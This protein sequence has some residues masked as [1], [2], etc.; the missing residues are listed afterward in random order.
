MKKEDKFIGIDGTIRDWKTLENDYL[1]NITRTRRSNYKGPIVRLTEL[2]STFTNPKEQIIIR[3]IRRY[4]H[5]II[6]LN[7]NQQLQII[8]DFDNRGYNVLLYDS[9][10]KEQTSFGKQITWAFRYKEFR[11]SEL[12]ELAE[13]LNI[14]ACLYC[15]SQY[16]L[17][18]EQGKSKIAKLQF[19]HF[20]PKSLYPYLSISLYNLIPSCASCNNSKSDNFYDL[21]IFS[22]PHLED[23]HILFNF[24]IPLKS[25][26]KL[27]MGN[28]VPTNEMKPLIPLPIN[29]KVKNYDKVFHLTG[30]Y[31]RHTDIVKEI[32]Y[33]AYAYKEGGKEAL[34]KI[35]DKKGRKIFNDESEIQKMLL[36]NY[37]LDEDI[38]KRPLTKFMQDMARNSGLIK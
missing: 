12:V 21:S 19:D 4:F 6:L 18:V 36:A 38:N 22:H 31:Q 35:A 8:K 14:K 25:H 9:I 7:P 15:N 26:T 11:E 34:M 2:L 3:S 30:I 27:L 37:T 1:K 10:K 13:N 16:T 5:K 32:Y 24:S 23:F 33:K 29:P 20:F 28:D 17:V